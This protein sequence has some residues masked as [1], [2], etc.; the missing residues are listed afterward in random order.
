VPVSAL[1]SSWSRTE[2][3]EDSSL[4]QEI[5][6]LVQLHKLER[7]TGT[8]SLLFGELVEP[9]E[10]QLQKRGQKEGE[11]KREKK[12]DR[13]RREGEREKGRK[14]KRREE[15]GEKKTERRRK[16]QKEEKKR[17]RK[18]LS[19]ILTVLSYFLALPHCCLSSSISQKRERFQENG[20]HT[21]RR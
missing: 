10:G 8:I 4:C 16:E 14:R 17:R 2:I 5:I 21:D 15:E 12:G 19:P 18:G 13:K 7:R 1:P 20:A 3:D 11:G 9:E 6:L